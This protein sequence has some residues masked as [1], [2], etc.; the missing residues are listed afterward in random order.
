MPKR[1][2][3][4]NAKPRSTEEFA[5]IYGSQARVDWVKAHPCVFCGRVPCDNAH[6]TNGGTGRKADARFIIPA[7]S[8]YESDGQIVTGCH[9]Q[10]DH[11][12]GKGALARQHDLNLLD[13]AAK[14]DL[15]WRLEGLAA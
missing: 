7:C 11:G 8:N 9:H 10:M 1:S 3:W 2:G 12:I 14:I 13:E 4:I 15:E 6:V 5:R